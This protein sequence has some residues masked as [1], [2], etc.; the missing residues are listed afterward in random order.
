MFLPLN[1]GFFRPNMFSQS[2]LA[3]E[4]EKAAKK[5][6]FQKVVL[7]PWIHPYVICFPEKPVCSD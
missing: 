2:V 6:F 7:F 4:H 1:P 5:K 3:I